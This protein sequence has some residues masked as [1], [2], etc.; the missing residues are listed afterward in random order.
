M[1]LFEGDGWLVVDKPAG[2]LVIPGRAQGTPSLREQ[3]EAERKQKIFVVHRLDRDTSGVLV[4]ALN[5]EVHRELSMALEA[6]EAE[7]T[8]L[9]LVEGALTEPMTVNAAL[10]AGRKGRMRVARGGE[11]GKASITQLRPVE[12]LRN[13]TLVE[14]KPKTGRTH[15]I[16]VHLQSIGHPLIFDPQYGK[17]E[18]VAGLSRTPL[19][20]AELRMAGR[21]FTAPL[22]SDLAQALTQLRR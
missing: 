7:K 21:V 13:A 8:Y 2:V 4:F 19:H 16:R 20:A 17:D 14:V 12:S 9:A 10:T 1:I 11:E 6:G 15:Q 22:P 3:L 5:A 18:P